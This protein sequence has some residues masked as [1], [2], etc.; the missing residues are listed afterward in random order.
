MKPRTIDEYLAEVEPEQRRALERLRKAIKAAAP[1]AEECIS[2]GLAGFR[3]RGRMLV[4]MGAARKHCSFFP[5]GLPLVSFEKELHGFDT[6]KG[7]IRFQP[8]APLPIALVRKIVKA[9]IAENAE[10]DAKRKA[11]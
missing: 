3:L 9:R 5:G 7:T 6:S 10:L 1:E 4:W 2:Y 8:D 11:R